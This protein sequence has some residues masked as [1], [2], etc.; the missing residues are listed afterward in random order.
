LSLNKQ[1]PTALCV[2]PW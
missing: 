2:A 1:V